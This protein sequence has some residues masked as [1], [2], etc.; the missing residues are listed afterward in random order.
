M[1]EIIQTAYSRFYQTTKSSDLVKVLDLWAEMFKDDDPVVVAVAVKNLIKTLEFPPTIA[2]VRKEVAKLV[3]VTANEPTATDEY[4]AIRQAIKSSGY[5]SVENFEKLPAVAKQFVG[6]PN[7]L[8]DWALREDFNEEV[9]RGQFFKQYDTIKEQQKYK[10]MLDTNPQ[11]NN[12]IQSIANSKAALYA[13]EG[14]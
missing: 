12:L 2:D 3:N 14:E 10:R 1:L 9:L 5:Y 7:Q 8:K 4:N 11:L 13:G 6:N